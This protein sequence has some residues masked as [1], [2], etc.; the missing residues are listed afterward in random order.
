MLVRVSSLG[1]GFLDDSTSFS[2]GWILVGVSPI[3]WIL[4]GV[5]PLGWI[6]VGVSSLGCGDGFSDD[7]MSFFFRLDLS[8]GVI[9]GLW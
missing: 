6:L 9:L 2:F 1:C 7:S 5:S 8:W 4:V 3:G